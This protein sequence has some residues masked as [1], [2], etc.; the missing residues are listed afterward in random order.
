MKHFIKGGWPIYGIPLGIIMLN[1]KF[2]RPIGDIG[3]ARTF[4]FPVAY[5]VLYNVDPQ[6]LTVNNNPE[7][8]GIL[9]NAAEKLEKL[10]VGAIM[11]SCGLLL[12]YQ[13]QLA[14]IVK[15]PVATSSLL[16]LPLIGNIISAEKKVAVICSKSSNLSIDT[17][18]EFVNWDIDRLIIDGL[19]N[20]K[21]FNR[22]INNQQPP[23]EMDIN[24]IYFEL[25]ELCRNLINQEPDIAMLLLECTNLGPFSNR[26]SI[27]LG[28]PV[29]DFK[30]LA[31]ILQMA[32]PSS[33]KV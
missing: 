31:Y 5:E 26:L 13:K 4:S 2:P 6:D 32:I 21:N 16:L 7:A 15:I 14:S 23:Y 19:E 24:I 10:G 11:T 17:I 25:L 18:K 8:I 3:H 1:C 22:I 28:L 9:L 29:F 33:E 30:Q 27:D 20:C 12:R